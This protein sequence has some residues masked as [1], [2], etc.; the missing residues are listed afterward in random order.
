M[1]ARVRVCDGVERKVGR[2]VGRRRYEG[3]S[4]SLRWS[5]SGVMENR[6]V[7]VEFYARASTVLLTS[8]H[9]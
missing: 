7:G 2:Q 1:R 9:K 5:D 4:D 6:L 3:L 8:V